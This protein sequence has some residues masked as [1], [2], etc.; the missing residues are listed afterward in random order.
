MSKTAT[1]ILIVG[2]ILAF[3]GGVGYYVYSNV[4]MAMKFCYRIS[5]FKITSISNERVSFNLAVKI[6]NRS[7]FRVKVESL[8]LKIY[9]DGV[10][11]ATINQSVLQEIERLA[12]SEL[13]IPVSVELKNIGALKF[14]QIRQLAVKAFSQPDKF[15]V[16][17][18]GVLTGSVQGV[19]VKDFPISIGIS[20]SE[21]TAPSTDDDICKNFK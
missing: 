12:V 4:V 9:M 14:E 11:V 18:E 10:H 3:L 17:T 8:N 5:A 20:F 2:A 1:K 21:I 15:I 16:L 7:D 19:K 13:K 6:K